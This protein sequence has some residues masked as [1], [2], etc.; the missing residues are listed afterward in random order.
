MT[1]LAVLPFRPRR[2]RL[3]LAAKPR[4]ARTLGHARRRRGSTIPRAFVW[5]G[6]GK[7]RCRCLA[8]DREFTST[9]VN[10]RLCAGCRRRIAS[11]ALGDAEVFLAGER[12]TRT[13][14]HPRS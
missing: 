5:A 13:Q 8:C 6:G 9:A 14:A 10:L 4:S 11:G 1:P 3:R 12:G 2:G 7:R